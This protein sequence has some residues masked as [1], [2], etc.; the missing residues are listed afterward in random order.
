MPL[1][2]TVPFSVM[3]NGRPAGWAIEYSSLILEVS[4]SAIS[5]LSTS[6]AV[7]GG[8]KQA[9]N[10]YWCWSMT[11]T[12]MLWKFLASR[13]FIHPPLEVSGPERATP[14]ALARTALKQAVS[15]A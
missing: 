10:G 14:G 2:A 12:P 7:V 5:G 8:L 13:F 6:F 15:S 4:Q 3:R 11:L 9:L 1:Q